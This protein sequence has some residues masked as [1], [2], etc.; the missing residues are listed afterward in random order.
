MQQTVFC[1]I[2]YPDTFA[3]CFNATNRTEK[4]T[5]STTFKEYFIAIDRAE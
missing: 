3:K 4:E 1:K 5:R 2:H